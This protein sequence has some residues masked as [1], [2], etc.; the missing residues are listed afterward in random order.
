M[1][2]WRKRAGAWIR[3]GKNRKRLLISA[4]FLAAVLISYTAG[5][6][7][8][9]RGTPFVGE[10]KAID[11][12]SFLVDR[13]SEWNGIND[14]GEVC[15]ETDIFTVVDY[16]GVPASTEDLQ[17]GDRIKVTAYGSIMESYP[18]MYAEPVTH[19]EI[20]NDDF[21]DREKGD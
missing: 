11:G 20:L 16:N 8:G 4:G 1:E 13:P 21:E 9:L 19:I 12:N 5:R 14:R 17:V 6:I 10:I 2:S 3:N 7:T 15:F 18:S